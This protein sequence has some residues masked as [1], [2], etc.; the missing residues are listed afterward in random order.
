MSVSLFH[1]KKRKP[2]CLFLHGV[3]GESAGFG[4]FGRFSDDNRCEKRL[5]RKIS[6]KISGIFARMQKLSLRMPVTSLIGGGESS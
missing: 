5:F 4:L 1:D 3:C 2:I 6:A